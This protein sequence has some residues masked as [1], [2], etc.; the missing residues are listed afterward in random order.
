[1]IFMKKSTY[2]IIGLSLALAPLSFAQEAPAP[3]AVAQPSAQEVKEGFSYLIGQQLG[4]SLASD[5][6]ELQI[7]DLDAAMLM[8]GIEDGMANRVDPEMAKKDVRAIMNAFVAE[9]EKRTLA[10]AEVNAAA[11]KAFL[12]ENAKKE[13]VTTLPSGLQYKVLTAGTGRKYDAAKDGASAIAL[14]AYEGRKIDGTVFD[15]S[16]APVQFPL[17][18]VI[19][20]FSEALKLMPIGSEWEIYIPSELAYGE[21]GP[22]IIGPNATLIFKLKLADIQPGS[23]GSP[24]ELTPEQ[25]QQLMNQQR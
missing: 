11:G 6:S 15:A 5:L 13:G 10:K 18:G 22:G 17:D 9:M 16:E 1:M 19:P 14:V 2:T 21:Q 12:A 24:M 25:I 4:S 7:S 3:V 8:K 20:G 23:Q